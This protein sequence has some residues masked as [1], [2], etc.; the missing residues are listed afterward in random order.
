MTSIIATPIRLH[1]CEKSPHHGGLSRGRFRQR[2]Q[3]CTRACLC[4][5]LYVCAYTLKGAGWRTR[6]RSALSPEPKLLHVIAVDIDA[7]Q[8]L[9]QCRTPCKAG[10]YNFLGNGVE[11]SAWT[12]MEAQA[13]QPPP[14]I[15]SRENA[16]RRAF[17]VP[18]HAIVLPTAAI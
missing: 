2:R 17:S 11:S 5:C 1:A 8:D 13:N 9:H 16:E 12:E 14:Q 7:D 3:V 6:A 18:G 10:V 4:A 15:P